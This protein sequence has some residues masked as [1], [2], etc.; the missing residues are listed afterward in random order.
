MSSASGGQGGERADGGCGRGY[1]VYI[2]FVYSASSSRRSLSLLAEA[3]REAF[4]HNVKAMEDQLAEMEARVAERKR[5]DEEAEAVR[6]KRE[7]EAAARQA[8]ERKKL[9][10]E[11]VR[12]VAGGKCVCAR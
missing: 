10:S 4:M 12:A 9:F 6:L 2:S 3:K 5:L 1:V 11:M 7:Q 8:E